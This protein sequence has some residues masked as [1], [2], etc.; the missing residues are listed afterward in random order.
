[1]L[2]IIISRINYLPSAYSRTLS[3]DLDI[4]YWLGGCHATNHGDLIPY[5]TT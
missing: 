3:N 1:M 4:H 2:K 5:Q